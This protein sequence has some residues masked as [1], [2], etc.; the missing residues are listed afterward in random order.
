VVEMANNQVAVAMLNQKMQ[1]RDR[2]ATA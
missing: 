2:I 1:E